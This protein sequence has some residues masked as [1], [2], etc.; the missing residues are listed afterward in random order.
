MRILYRLS[1]L[2]ILLLFPLSNILLAETTDSLR[3]LLQNSDYPKV[4][5]AH[6]NYEIANSYYG[7][8]IYDSALLYST[9]A[10]IVYRQL[11]KEEEYARVEKLHRELLF[12]LDYF[13]ELIP[14]Q[15]N[16]IQDLIN[17]GD[18]ALMLDAYDHLGRIF[19]LNNQPDSAYYYYQKSYD[20]GKAT[21]NNRALMNSYNN[22][23]LLLEF[24]GDYNKQLEYLK[25]GLAI[26]IQL[27]IDRS[28]ASFYHNTALSFINLNELDSALIYVNNAV[29]INEKIRDNDRLALNKTAIGNIYGM[30]GDIHKSIVYFSEVLDYDKK[31][32]SINGQIDGNHNMGFSYY[33][34]GEYSSARKYYFEALRLAKRINSAYSL[35]DLYKNLAAVYQEEKN[36]AK[37]LKYYE[38]FHT[39]SDSLSNSTN[40]KMLLKVRAEYDYERNIAKIK[41]L[42][43]ENELK[44]RQVIFLYIISTITIFSFI[45]LG[46]LLFI[47][48][49]RF[50]N[51]KELNHQLQLQNLAIKES[52]HH[53]EVVENKTI[54]DLKFANTLQKEMFSD[55]HD[56]QSVFGVSYFKAFSRKP[57]KNAFLW[58]NRVDDILFCAVVNIRQEHFKGAFSSLYLFNVLNKVFFEKKYDDIKS[59][60]NLFVQEVFPETNGQDLGAI[61][62]YFS[63]FDIKKLELE[64]VNI[65]LDIELVRNTKVWE[66]KSNIDLLSRDIPHVSEI[67]KIQFQENDKL[68]LYCENLGV[69]SNNNL[70]S[71]SQHL[72]KEEETRMHKPIDADKFINKLMNDSSINEFVFLLL[73]I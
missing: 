14:F 38:L 58:T 41:L 9:Q 43:K 21:N 28:K 2:G 48:F 45:V 23:S 13:G 49:K 22:F 7:E 65:G 26:A 11:G 35:K 12:Q 50:K 51:N 6:L 5:L 71:A 10:L 44:Q 39:I 24:Y 27:D 16:V 55:T 69:D 15:Y 72:F 53:L 29:H 1:F 67:R 37:A 73:E 25:K 46:I 3:I 70:F 19:Y 63:S 57:I 18:S 54:D 40:H 60:L 34:L 33:M 62:M 20:I 32:G 17:N 47:I 31:S 56:L 66:F 52:N 36:D 61:Q 59:F 8:N 42:S 64:F 68:V 30:K 4:E